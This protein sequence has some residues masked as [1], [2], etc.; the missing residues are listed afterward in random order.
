M[1]LNRN[2]PVKMS[3][4]GGFRTGS[5]QPT[6]Q[7]FR[8]KSLFATEQ[9]SSRKLPVHSHGGLHPMIVHKCWSDALAWSCPSHD[10]FTKSWSM[11]AGWFGGTMTIFV[12]QVGFD[13]W[14]IWVFWKGIIPNSGNPGLIT[15]RFVRRIFSFFRI[16]HPGPI[17]QKFLA[18]S[19]APK[20]SGLDHRFSL[21]TCIH[22]CIYVCIYIYHIG[23]EIDR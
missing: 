21:C 10:C 5:L 3:V 23:R 13:F 8:G 4:I 17:W 16:W 11:T 20:N 22:I 15:G 7:I 19:W 6:L 9:C 2:L 18:S 14:E 1:P 12:S